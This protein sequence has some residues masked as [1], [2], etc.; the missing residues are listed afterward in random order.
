MNAVFFNAV[1]GVI[2]ILALVLNVFMLYALHR[3]A[4][5]ETRGSLK[6]VLLKNISF[7]GIV[8]VIFGYSVQLM[9][10]V[11]HE[12]KL[13]FCKVSGF[14]VTFCGLVSIAFMTILS[15]DICVHICRPLKG[16]VYDS[17]SSKVY[18]LFGWLY[19]FIWAVAP[20]FG[21]DGYIIEGKKSCSMNWVQDSIKAKAYLLLLFFFC[22]MLPFTIILTCFG[23]IHLNMK[24]KLRL[25]LSSN[26]STKNPSKLFR[27]V[28]LGN[29]KLCFYI[30]VTFLF[31]WTPY[32]V[33]SG[34]IF[35]YGYNAVPDDL[36]L[37]AALAA[38]CSAIFNP[39]IYFYY[40][41]TARLY[42]S[43]HLACRE[44]ESFF[45]TGGGTETRERNRDSTSERRAHTDFIQ[46]PRDLLKTQSIPR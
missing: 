7:I 11:I 34:Y 43:N 5:R 36:L 18:I 29:V 16:M 42:L 17:R 46:I 37:G 25:S 22:Y 3:T 31:A 12:Y 27:T 8:V 21:L 10:S 15:F 41:R 39:L 9:D 33:I 4:K 40:N 30:S 13:G 14:F 35:I 6:N 38:K 19:G 26:S 45:M 1:L 24:R 44:V 23:C 2:A 28:R 20:F 32:A